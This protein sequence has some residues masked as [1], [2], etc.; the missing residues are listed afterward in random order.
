MHVLPESGL[1]FKQTAGTELPIDTNPETLL[2]G[3][4]ETSMVK[5]LFSFST[6]VLRST[7]NRIWRLFQE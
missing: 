1:R 7:A 6:M 2:Y 4:L 3:N 5:I